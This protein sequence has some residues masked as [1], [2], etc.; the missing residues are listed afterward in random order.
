M[1][2]KINP[3]TTEFTEFYTE[4]TESPFTNHAYPVTAFFQQTG[5][6][7]YACFKRSDG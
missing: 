2:V 5:N 6:D 7:C 3:L 4:G 1:A